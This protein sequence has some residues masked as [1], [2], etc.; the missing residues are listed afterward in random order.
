LIAK[1]QSRKV[2]GFFAFC[3]EDEH[4]PPGAPRH[5]LFT[6]SGLIHLRMCAARCG[7]RQAGAGIESQAHALTA[8]KS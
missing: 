6:V 7:M 2:L 4:T 3:A 5:E 1:A 8:M